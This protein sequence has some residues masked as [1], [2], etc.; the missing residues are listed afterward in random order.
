MFW[1]TLVFLCAELEVANTIDKE[2]RIYSTS[3]RYSQTVS[4]F[5]KQ[6]PKGESI[7]DKLENIVLNVKNAES[8][9][10]KNIKQLQKEIEQLEAK[11]NQLQS[12]ILGLGD[13]K[14]TTLNTLESL[15]KLQ[16]AI[17]RE[18]D[19]QIVEAPSEPDIAG[20]DIMGAE[21]FFTESKHMIVMDVLSNESKVGCKDERL[22]LF[23]SDEGYERAKEAEQAGHIKIK[24]HAEVVSGELYFDKPSKNSPLEKEIATRIREGGFS[25]T[26]LTIKYIHALDSMFG[27][28]HSV[29]EVCDK[30]K[31]QFFSSPDEKNIVNKLAEEFKRQELEKGFCQEV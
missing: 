17:R 15:D 9:Y 16:Q 24:G 29:K 3:F 7:A 13:I 28:K 27:K 19:T 12:E 26:P 1:Y 21:R 30:F 18:R 6:W 4:D 31:K 5:L 25:P 11:K 23:L 8:E 14:T 2:P 10:N 22:R 20:Q